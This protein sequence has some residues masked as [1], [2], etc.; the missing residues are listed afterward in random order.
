MPSQS[1][2]MHKA[3]PQWAMRWRSSASC[4][5][6]PA[7]LRLVQATRSESGSLTAWVFATDVVTASMTLY[8]KWTPNSYTIAFDGNG[9]TAVDSITQEYGSAVMAPADPMRTGYTFA[10]WSPAMPATMPLGGAN[11][12]AQWTAIQYSIV[13]DSAGGSAVASIDLGYG[14]VVTPP[15]DPTR[16]GYAFAGWS[17]A[18]PATMPLN[19]ASLTARWTVNQYAITFDSHGGSL[20]GSLSLDFGTKITAPSNPTRTGWIRGLVP[21]RGLCDGLGFPQ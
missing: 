5:S 11:L 21:R 2:S 20:V 1:L 4:W 14:T 13:F 15:A 18:M 12:T 10:G 19:G 6:N 3:A 16:T 8:A 9:G 7:R 17:P